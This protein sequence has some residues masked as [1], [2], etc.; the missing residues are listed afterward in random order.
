MDLCPQRGC[1]GVEGKRSSMEV[2]QWNEILEPYALAV[3]EIVVKFNHIITAYR[4]MGKYSPIERVEGRVKAISSIMDK[5][6]KKGIGL[7]EVEEKIDDIAGIRV[8][9]QFVDDIYK[10]LELIKRRS[11]MKITSKRDYVKNPKPSGY[12]S[13]H[14][15]VLYQVETLRGPKE[16]TVEIQIR[17]MGMNF[18]A[19]IEHSLQYKYKLGMTN[20]SSNRLLHDAA[21]AVAKLDEEM[22]Q[23]RVAIVDGQKEFDERSALVALIMQG[24][25]TLKKSAQSS[26]VSAFQKQFMDI[27]EEGE[28]VKL[29]NFYDKLELELALI[30]TK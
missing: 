30:T 1:A 7:D 6:R 12:R 10:V 5:A 22:S 18:W 21:E 8:I 23:V 19:T 26:V 27:Y 2:Q 9:C 16:I 25:Q 24:L 4:N 11:D 28:L 29:R 13:F 3:D 20:E 15:N 14:M 17:T